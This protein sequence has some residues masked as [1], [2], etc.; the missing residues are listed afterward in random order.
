METINFKTTI[1]CNGCISKVTPTLNNLVGES[2]W[3]VDIST[4]DKIL[5]VENSDVSTEQIIQ[6]VKSLGFQITKQ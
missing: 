1:N 5:S 2:N 3:N 4:S 6:S